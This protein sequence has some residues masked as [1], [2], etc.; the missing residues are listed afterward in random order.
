MNI[1]KEYQTHSVEHR[2][3]G[4]GWAVVQPLPD[5]CCRLAPF[6]TNEEGE[7]KVGNQL[8][9][10]WNKMLKLE[11]ERKQDENKNWVL[12]GKNLELPRDIIATINKIRDKLYSGEYAVE[13]TRLVKAT[14]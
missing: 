5:N 11:P 10:A 1:P 9:L 2:Y 14:P 6:F 3:G 12:T 8:F 13:N 7:W 4:N